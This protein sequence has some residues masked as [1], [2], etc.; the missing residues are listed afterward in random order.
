MQRNWILQDPIFNFQS[1]QTIPYRNLGQIARIIL[2]I[3][4]GVFKKFLRTENRKPKDKRLLEEIVK[5]YF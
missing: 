3:K 4:S 2:F 1:S 5:Q